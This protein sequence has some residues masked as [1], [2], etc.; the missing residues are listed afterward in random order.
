M[1]PMIRRRIAAL[2]VG[3]AGWSLLA[4]T[5][6][7]PAVTQPA[8]PPSP[9][10]S[11]ALA[12]LR[13]AATA[14]AR[15]SYEGTRTS[16]L[17][18]GRVQAFQVRVYH[19]APD[20]TRLEYLAVGDQPARIVVIAGSSQTT[21][22]PATNKMIRAPAVRT[23]EEA[24]TRQI[25]PQIAENYTV[26][27]A[28]TQRVAGRAVQVIDVQGKFPGRPRLRL[29]VDTQTRLILR[30][31]RYSPTGALRQESTFIELRLNP[32]FPPGLFV[33]AAPPGVQITT[34][35]P[36]PELTIEGI[37]SRVGFTPPLPAYLPA[38]YKL[39]NSRV[40]NLRGVPTAVF[41]FSDGVATLTLFES[42]GAQGAPPNAQQVRIDGTP[43]TI[44][45]R[46]VASVL[47]WNVRGLS[48][49]LVGDLPQREMVRVGAS[50][51]L[52][53]TSEAP[54]EWGRGVRAWLATAFAMPAAEAAVAPPAGEEPAA[55]PGP[56][57]PYITNNTH[58]IGSGIV[59]EERAVW[60]A[61]VARGLAPAVVKV[62]IASDGVT[63]LPDGRLA[64]LAWVWFVYGMN[65]TGGADAAVRTVQAHAY[66][67]AVTTFEVDR[68]V[69]RVVLTGYYHQS[70]RFDGRRTDATFTAELG[71]GGLLGGPANP[72]PGRALAHAGDVWYSPALLA[73][74]LVEQPAEPH[75]P[76]L[77]PAE[78]SRLP[79]PPGDRT[80]ESSENYHGSL[81]ASI[82]E[83][84]RRLQGLLF[85]GENQGRLWRG[86]PLRR[87]IAL[88]F[89]D[90]PSPL[91]TPLL[92]SILRRYGV[93]A[94]FFVIGEHARAYPYL[95]REMAA[96]GDE[97]GD[98]T[99]HHPDLASVDDATVAQEIDA[100][101]TV[102]EQATAY[103]PRWLR[104]PGGDYTDA[105]V[106]AAGHAGLG[107]AMWTDNSGDWALPPAK[108][109]V[110]HVLVHAEPGGVVLMHNGTLNTVRALP[111]IIV[112]LRQRGYRFVTISQLIRDTK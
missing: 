42:L 92:L 93:H 18:A 69:T 88:T 12:W 11:T 72:S 39:A 30:F 77:P 5:L 82:V 8:G 104:P 85:G 22:T 87:E 108:L 100:T 63:K 83:M 65:W 35:R 26:R 50:L 23:D 3:V 71:R 1:M 101:I 80:M 49:T 76:H 56:I 86:D 7:P 44:T 94:T 51:R 84:K 16:T 9:A 31:E 13:A 10:D 73:G 25:L 96:D 6:S 89:D 29:W 34:R 90:G 61:F 111:T 112:D 20:L 91:A 28:G 36:A 45:T 109:V 54:V 48:F 78:R 59:E 75:D 74:D 32:T 40:V 64:R 55:P 47:H 53:G 15:V 106:A 2:A 67:L 52:P 43:A 62:T 19:Q 21:Y 81:V 14:P 70:G 24:L 107:V 37:A 58:V 57:S 17:W 103:R 99:F 110:Q 27:F 33:L 46:G 66:A 60:R 79:R 4:A 97:I 41:A 68:R 98:H 38:G 105:V 95:L 102:V